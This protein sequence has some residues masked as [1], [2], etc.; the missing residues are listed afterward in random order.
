M[1]FTVIKVRYLDK[2]KENAGSKLSNA[3]FTGFLMMTI[4]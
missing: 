2:L 4:M 3:A 1:N